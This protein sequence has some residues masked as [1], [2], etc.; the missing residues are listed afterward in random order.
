VR[1]KNY[2]PEGEVEMDKDGRGEG[3]GNARMMMMTHILSPQ[4]CGGGG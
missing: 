1:K 2:D 4:V 3:R